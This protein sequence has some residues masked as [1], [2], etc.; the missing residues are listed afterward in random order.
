MLPPLLLLLLCWG[1]VATNVTVRGWAPDQTRGCSARQNGRLHT[2]QPQQGG[3]GW[4][5]PGHSQ[6]Q[7]PQHPVTHGAQQQTPECMTVQL[8]VMLGGW[9]AKGTAW[10]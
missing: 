7:R 3:G 6:L 1:L 4:Q 5:E 8:A 10:R 2:W 9:G